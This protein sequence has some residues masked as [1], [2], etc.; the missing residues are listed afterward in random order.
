[1]NG[2]E[3]AN[4]VVSALSN[5]PLG[6]PSDA[7]AFN[8]DQSDSG[9]P[10]IEVRD[11]PLREIEAA[12]RAALELRQDALPDS[13]RIYTQDGRLVWVREEQGKNKTVREVRKPG[14]GES[15]GR[16]ITLR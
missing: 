11:Q 9:L 3:A 15:H 5:E 16:A 14:P 6:I 7:E 12:S 1:M 13:E 10:R 2:H 8:D 4:T